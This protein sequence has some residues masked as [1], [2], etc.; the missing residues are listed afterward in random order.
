MRAGEK[1]TTEDKMIGW[2]HRLNRREFEQALGVGDEQG[3][4]AHCIPWGC[5]ELD[6]L[7]D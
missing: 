7:S 3:R 6:T 1:G 2:Y 5:K 4:L